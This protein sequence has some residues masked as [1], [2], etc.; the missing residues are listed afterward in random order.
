MFS[1]SLAT[2]WG[3]NGILEHTIAGAVAGTLYK[4]KLGP[5]AWVVGGGLGLVLGTIA[6]A[7]T[8][9]LLSL[10]GMTMEEVRYWNYKWV[11]ARSDSYDKE[12]KKHLEKEQMQILTE[13]DSRFE[14]S[15]NTGNYL[16]NVEISDK[17]KNIKNK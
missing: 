6:G 3:K 13:R 4:F 2:Y 14:N 1:T 16:E 15:A 11:Q 8:S 7:G 12:F 5:R 17:N 10:T 9:A